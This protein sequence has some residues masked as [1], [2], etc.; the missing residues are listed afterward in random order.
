MVVNDLGGSV[1]GQGSSTE[2]A[3]VVVKEIIRAGGRAAANFESV[4]N[5]DRIV[6]FVIQTFGRIDIVINNAG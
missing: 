3:N 6:G 1:H 5:G 2:P 4:E